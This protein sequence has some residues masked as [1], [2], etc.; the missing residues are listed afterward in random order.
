MIQAHRT[1]HRER[2][3][4]DEAERSFREAIRIDLSELAPGSA[5]EQK[6]LAAYGTD[7]QQGDIVVLD[8]LRY[9]ISC[10]SK[11][12]TPTPEPTTTR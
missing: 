6:L 1:C 4:T 9:K 8:N 11:H 12:T 10:K 3:R 2:G 5:I 7:I